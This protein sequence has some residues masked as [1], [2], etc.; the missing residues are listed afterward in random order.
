[1]KKILLLLLLSFT[2]TLFAQ[3][4]TL[5]GIVQDK[6]SIVLEGATVYLQSIKDSIPMSYGITNKNGEFSIP[7]NAEDDSKVIFNVAYLGYKPFIKDINVPEGKALNIGAITIEEQVEE[8]NVVS[9]IAKAPPILI[10]KDTIEYNADS[11]KTLPNDKAED[12]LK[13]LPGIEIDIDGN[14][15]M[16]GIEVE[17]VNVDGMAFFGEKS[18]D[19]A[20]KNLPSNV[21]SKVQVTDYKTNT[22]KFTGEESDSGTKEINLTIK[23]GKNRATFGDVKAGYGTDEK[24]QVN[25]N[26]FKLIE[27][28]QLGL[29]GGTNNINMTRGFNSLPDT[30]TSNGYIESDFIGANFTK[31]KWNETRVNG[32]YRYSAQSTDN[33]QI[34]HT[35]NFLPDFNYTTDSE[36]KGYSDSDNHRAGGDLKFIIPSKNKGSNNKVQISNEIDVNVSSSESG[37]VSDINSEY[38]NGD[39]VS[40]YNSKNHTLSDGYSVNNEFSVTTVTGN[41]DYLTMSVNTDFSKENIETESYSENYIVRLNSTDIQDQINNRDNNSS[42][43]SF[44]ALWNKELFTNFRI[45]PEYNARITSQKNENYIFDFNENTNNYDDF[46]EIQSSDS[47]YTTTTLIPALRLR[48]EYKD[49][50]FELKA[51]YTNTFRNYTDKLVEARDF[52]TNFEYVTYSGRIRYRDKN[53]YKNINLNYNQNVN[54][55]SVNQLQPVIDESNITHVVIGNPFLEPEVS[56]NINFQYQNN[57]AFNNINVTGSLRAEFIEDKIIS[58][59]ITDEDLIRYTTYD[60]ING[61]YS[62]S[63]N[64]AV[65]KSFYNQKTN[66]NI[67]GRVNGSFNKALSIQN[68]I[69]FT[70]ETTNIRP[71]LSFKYLYNDKLDLSASY[72]YSFTSVV[73]DTDAF[74]D[75]RYFVQ[76]VDLEASIFFLK[77]IFLTNKV[78]YRYNSR[79]GDEFDGDAVFW[80]AGLGIEL[81]E[82][83]ATVTL[84]GYD[85]LGKNNGYRR[86]VTETSIQDSETNIL[87]QYYMLNF[88]YKFGNF[89]GQRMNIGGDKGNRRGSNL[90]GGARR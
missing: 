80:N 45:I 85:M 58:S 10:K 20:L 11:F 56:H 46:N 35:E 34:S 39:L 67:N 72:S 79:V 78:S 28:K 4:F 25:A 60:N 15:T 37:S 17:A 52:K 61:N 83:K 2:G 31:G 75:N 30:D 23:K 88:T 62:Y 47:K 18:G 36:S 1:M 50:R 43:I 57:I 27:G 8:L 9:I 29:I 69:E 41:R 70:G 3:K 68:G 64:A 21:I 71:S 32:N 63:G 38:T 51:G 54:L 26:I 14:I 86:T 74:N 77:N 7:V 84:V 19:I 48:Y 44:G 33:E 65:T 66:I 87:E 59:T 12:L 22:Q 16:N 40:D 89:A 73:Y 13:K 24:Y 81:W 5:E 6:N 42:N 82:N 55:P 90:G 53:G 49:F 76:N